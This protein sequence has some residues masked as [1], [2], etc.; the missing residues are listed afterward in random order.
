MK[1]TM[2]KIEILKVVFKPTRV[3]GK[4]KFRYQ[5][6]YPLDSPEV[7]EWQKGGSSAIPE[8][9][10]A[11]TYPKLLKYLHFSAIK[12]LNILLKKSNFYFCFFFQ[13]PNSMKRLFLIQFSLTI[14]LLRFY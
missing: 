14:L 9:I 8:P 3:P 6:P 4:T 1:E 10:P 13:I 7:V 11:Q 12:S 2:R 5:L